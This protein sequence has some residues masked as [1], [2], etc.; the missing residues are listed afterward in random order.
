[1]KVGSD[2]AMISMITYGPFNI[3]GME[4][5]AVGYA[6]YDKLLVTQFSNQPANPVLVNPWNSQPVNWY[7]EKEPNIVT[8]MKDS[9]GGEGG[10]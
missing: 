10:E 7:A 4:V 3:A 6:L 8:Y 5:H 1:M 9:F 2:V